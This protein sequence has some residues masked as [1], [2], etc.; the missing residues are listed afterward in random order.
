M[1][2]HL[3][4]YVKE[5]LD[6]LKREKNYSSHTVDAYRTDL[7]QFHQFIKYLDLD[8]K[9]LFEES[10]IEI[11]TIKLFIHKVLVYTKEQI[12]KGELNIDFSKEDNW[13]LY[14][15]DDWEKKQDKIIL[16]LLYS[17]GIT[18]NQLLD[19]DLVNLKLNQKKI[20]IS[21]KKGKKQTF[22]F[23]TK[24]EKAIRL[25]INDRKK[26]SSKN[27]L[28]DPLFVSREGVR[29]SMDI[30]RSR[31]NDYFLNV[32]RNSDF[33]L[34]FCRG[35]FATH[36]FENDID[37]TD[38]KDIFGEKTKFLLSHTGRF[39]ELYQLLKKPKAISA[40]SRSRKLSTVKSF[41]QFLL[42]KGL[43]KN[44]PATIIKS[45]KYKVNPP[46]VL[47]ETI[48]KI[49]LTPIDSED[50]EILRDRTILEVF[51]STGI[52]L[53]EL[54]Q[55]NLGDINFVD[56]EILIFGKGRKE[57]IVFF[58]KEV[59]NILKLYI[60]EHEIHLSKNYKGKEYGARPLFI[61]KKG[62]RIKPREVQERIKIFFEFVALK[63]SKKKNKRN[64]D[65]SILIN[66]INPTPHLFRHTFATHLIN[67]G[68]KMEIVKDLLGHEKLSTTQI[69]SHL[70]VKGMKKILDEAHP[71]A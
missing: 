36:L 47:E 8:N 56:N 49:L 28:N 51:Y 48:M 12:I 26:R 38:V 71:H 57:R 69:Y 44:N 20:I 43:I 32:E 68:V 58:G 2:D 17:T 9:T 3:E 18:P 53:T 29:F 1:S 14:K 62:N 27:N 34:K 70:D 15:K 61:T 24:I 22:H 67:S 13:I 65:L 5:F 16:L 41:F 63:I 55:I 25:F 19:L 33:T 10:I 42:K 21:D 59:A 66:S 35:L 45:P 46:Q 23:P 64:S 60:V 11:G 6:Y 54:T 31:I 40:R 39:N 7:L 52:R 4:K 50:W 37:I 30:L